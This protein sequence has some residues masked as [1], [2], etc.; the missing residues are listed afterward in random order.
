M[1]GWQG[2][3]YDGPFARTRK[4]AID[5]LHGEGFGIVTRTAYERIRAWCD[6]N[7]WPPSD[8][9]PGD[10]PWPPDGQAKKVW[11]CRHCGVNRRWPDDV[12]SECYEDEGST[13]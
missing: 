2:G 7:G 8:W 5:R 6:V 11:P 3:A 12:C 9:Q 13:R 10:G 4:E 1:S